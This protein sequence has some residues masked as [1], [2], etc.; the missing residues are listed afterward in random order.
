[1]LT[2]HCGHNEAD[3]GSIGGTG[4]MGIYLLLLMLVEGD[5]SIKNIVASKSVVGA[6]CI[7]V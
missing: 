1:M 4:E 5:E 3:L 7:L 6:T 2:I